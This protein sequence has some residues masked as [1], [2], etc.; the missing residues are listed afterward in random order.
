M[1]QWKR[2]CAYYENPDYADIAGNVYPKPPDIIAH[3]TSQIAS[4]MPFVT[5]A[6]VA[7]SLSRVASASAL[8]ESVRQVAAKLPVGSSKDVCGQTYVRSAGGEKEHLAVRW[9]NEAVRTNDVLCAGHP[10]ICVR[11]TDLPRNAE[12]LLSYCPEIDLTP[13]LYAVE[14]DVMTPTEG[15]ALDFAFWRK[16]SCWTWCKPTV[17]DAKT[18]RTFHDLRE[19]D[20]KAG[21]GRLVFRL[22]DVRAGDR[23]YI[24]GIRITRVAGTKTTGGDQ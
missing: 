2:V 13:G 7:R 9:P 12:G 23:F 17:L 24:G 16:A 19:L 14:I 18:W 8:P 22:P 15:M 3:L 5:D 1:A 4:V 21:G 11:W 20:A 6:D 10:T